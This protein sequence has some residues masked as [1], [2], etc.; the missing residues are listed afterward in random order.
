MDEKPERED[1]RVSVD[2]L[3]SEALEYHAEDQIFQELGDTADLVKEVAG[4]F[5]DGQTQLFAHPL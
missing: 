4:R 5:L 2:A 1:P 3:L